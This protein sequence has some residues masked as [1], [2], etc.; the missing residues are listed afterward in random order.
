MNSDIYINQVLEELRFP[1]YK[2]SIREKSAIISIDNG[3]GYHTFK[4]IAVYRC[5][6]RL[7]RIDWPAQ[8][9]NLKPIE[10]LWQIIKVRVNAKR[11]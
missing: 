8:S 7:I 11:H 1:F 6:I 2:Q 5:C 3:I 9:P 4:T 10:K